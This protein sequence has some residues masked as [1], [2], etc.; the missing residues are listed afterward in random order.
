M[1]VPGISSGSLYNTQ[2]VQSNAQQFRQE[3][4]QVGQDLP[5]GN[6]FASHQ[7]WLLCKI[8]E[9]D[10]GSGSSEISELLDPL[11][12]RAAIRQ[13][14]RCTT[15]LQ[16]TGPAFPAIVPDRCSADRVQVAV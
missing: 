15:A 9:H 10:G 11:G 4:Q 7:I 1:S 16:L 13:P 12:H 8:S 5:S 14:L 6:L 3:F 2:S